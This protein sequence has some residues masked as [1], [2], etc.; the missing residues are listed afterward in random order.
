MA[1]E[2]FDDKV[3][4]DTVASSG[5]D[6]VTPGYH[7][8]RVADVIEDDENIKVDLEVMPGGTKPSEVGKVHREFISRNS[9]DGNRKRRLA[10][11]L[12]ANLVTKDDMKAAQ[13]QGHG[14]EIDYP[15]AVGEL[16]VFEIEQERKQKKND[17]GQYVPD[18]DGKVVSKI[19]Y[20]HIWHVND[21]TVA[22]KGVK[23]DRTK[24]QMESAFGGDL[25]KPK[26]AAKADD[27]FF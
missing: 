12:A 26:T 27:A 18:P 17:E 9:K 2:Y 19:P 16:L 21:P 7:L 4:A 25:P 1:T 24:L 22:K 6:V 10:F 11:A 5:F 13:E 3:N 15:S 23:I 8:G 20:D 14:L